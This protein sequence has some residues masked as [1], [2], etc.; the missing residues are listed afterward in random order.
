MMQRDWIRPF[1]ICAMS[2]LMA[3]GCASAPD[4]RSWGGN[5]HWP[6][7]GSFRQALVTAAKDPQTWVP[8][9]GALALQIDDAD[10]NASRWLANEQPLFGRNAADTSDTLSN[11]TT[12]MYFATALAAPSAGLRD[13]G[14]GLAVGLGAIALNKAV[15]EGLKSAA[16]RERPNRQDNRSMPSGHASNASVSSAMAISNADYLPAPDWFRHGLTAG[17]YAMAGGA[18]LARVEAGEHYLSDVLV[19]YAL[20]HFIA[21]FMQQ[22]FI[23]AESPAVSVSFVPVTRGGVF[24]VSIPVGGAQGGLR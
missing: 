3:S 18:S 2:V 12:A 7:G 19:G 21:A 14:R 5:A 15:T 23:Q 13:K 9:A 24:T 11:L 4:D 8:L 10:E 20:G 6:G 17:L 1:T 22:A 16:G